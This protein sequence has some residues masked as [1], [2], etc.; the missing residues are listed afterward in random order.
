VGL[1]LW[2]TPPHPQKKRR[3][4]VVKGKPSQLKSL[5]LLQRMFTD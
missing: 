4:I 1:E 2:L 5:R 3:K